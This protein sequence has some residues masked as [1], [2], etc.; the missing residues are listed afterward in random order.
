[1][2]TARRT[3]MDT[4]SPK[5]VSFSGARVSK[6]RSVDPMKTLPRFTGLVR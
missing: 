5:T 3:M 6:S 1:M 2:R 4:E